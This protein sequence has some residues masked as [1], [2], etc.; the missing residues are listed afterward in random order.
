MPSSNPLFDITERGPSICAV[1]E[2]R[3]YST[4]S[5]DFAKGIAYQMRAWSG[6]S[7]AGV[8]ALK[9]GQLRDTLHRS[10]IAN[11]CI[12][13]RTTMRR[14]PGGGAQRPVSVNGSSQYFHNTS[15][16]P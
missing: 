13:Y 12:T 14:H 16:A 1:V 11:T 5:H 3:D 15:E 6:W 4:E 9:G 2:T 8:N 10:H 7:S